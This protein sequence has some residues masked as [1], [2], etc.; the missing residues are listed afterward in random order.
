M[1]SILISIQPKWVEK[2]CSGEKTIEVRKTRPKIDTPFKCYIYETKCEYKTGTCIFAYGVELK[3]TRKGRG[4]VIGEFVCDKVYDIKPYFDRPNLLTQYECGWKHGEEFTCL[5]FSDFF[6]YLKEDKGY[7]CHISKLKIYD[8]PK[9]LSEFYKE[10]NGICVDTAKK[11]L[12]LKTKTLK[13]F[14]CD[15]K[16]L[17]TRPPQSWCYVEDLGDLDL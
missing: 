13:S 5:S 9:E 12:C 17:L 11:I 6:S 4:K 15:R 10:C 8:K 14:N 16:I 3:R 7:G 2:I 1:K